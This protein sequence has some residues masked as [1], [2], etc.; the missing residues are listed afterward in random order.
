[1]TPA[2]RL[3]A[4]IE[5]LDHILAGDAAEKALTNWARHSRFAGS[6]D[7]AAVRDHVFGALR[8]KRS[9][10]HL[11]GAQT[12]RGIVLGLLRAQG[13]PPQDMFTGEGHAPTPMTE[14][15]AAHNATPDG[16]IALDCPDWIAPL[17]QSSL[18]D[19]FAAVCHALQSR[20]PVFLRVNTLKTNRDQ[21]ANALAAED[22]STQPHP[23]S[24]TA[25]EVT[26]NPRRVHLSAPYNDGHVELQDAASQAVVDLLPL[27]PDTR[28]LDY[29]AGGGGKVLAMAARVSAEYFAYDANP[30]RMKDLPARADRAGAVVTLLDS[31]DMTE[32]APFDLVL[33]D[34]PCSGSGAWRRAPAAKWTFDAEQLADLRQTQLEILA[35]AAGLVT[36]SGVLAYTTCSLLDAENSDQ[37]TQFIAENLDWKCVGQH[38]FTPLDGG[39]G[40]FCALLTRK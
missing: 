35:M 40:F 2:A 17:L 20:A 23:L 21:V 38:R 7:R 37:I 8:C 16:N 12:G 3:S 36:S 39:D 27:Q 9:Y 31:Q 26:Q 32:T 33:C 18:G 1:M 30:Q 10:A 28:V 29:C 11:G 13:I 6:K 4:A 25:L 22:I 14:D 19:D 15:E 5:L 34:V 24:P